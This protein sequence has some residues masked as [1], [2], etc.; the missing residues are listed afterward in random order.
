M[1]Q[2]T[3]VVP[4]GAD[5]PC[6]IG[7]AGTPANPR[8]QRC[9]NSCRIFARDAHPDTVIFAQAS[10]IRGARFNLEDINWDRCAGEAEELRQRGGEVCAGGEGVEW[11]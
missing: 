2:R 10:R 9:D 4:L 11:L 1:D 5:S 8:A 6:N 3:Q 7:A